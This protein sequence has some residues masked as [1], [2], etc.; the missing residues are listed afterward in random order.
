MKIKVM[1]R[2]EIEDFKTDENHI[3]ISIT[4][5]NSE[6]IKVNRTNLFDMISLQFHDVSKKLVKREDCK[7]CNGTGHL[8]FFAEINNGHC[9]SCTTAIDIILFNVKMAKHILDFVNMWKYSVD[10]IIVHCEAGISRS[11]GVASALSLILNGTDDYYFK[12]YLPNILCYRKIL[13]VYIRDKNE[14]NI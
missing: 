6:K 10:L 11:A 8:E 13:N 1:S 14:T 5:P 7:I 9:Y 3:I 4:D 2:R 12:H